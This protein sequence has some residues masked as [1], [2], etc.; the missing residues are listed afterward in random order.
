M[1]PLGFSRPEDV[2]IQ[3]LSYS[4][5]EQGFQLTEAWIEERLCDRCLWISVLNC[6]YRQEH[7]VRM[8]LQNILAALLPSN[9]DEVVV[10]IE[11]YGLPC[12]Q[13]VYSR[14]L[15]LRYMTHC[16]GPYEFDILT[17][18][19]EVSCPNPAIPA[20]FL[21]VVMN[22]GREEWLLA[23]KLFLEAPRENSNM[24]WV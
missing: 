1:E 23:S 21:N 9:V 8:R 7:I 2:M 24:I 11:S 19:E 4:L 22:Y 14:E 17:P 6:R 15:L 5:G 20:A 13:Y 18:R 3:S 16:I 10:I 12:Q